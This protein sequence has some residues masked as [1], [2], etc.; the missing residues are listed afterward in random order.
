MMIMIGWTMATTTMTIGNGYATVNEDR[1]VNLNTGVQTLPLDFYRNVLPGSIMISSDCLNI[2][3]QNYKDAMQTLNDKTVTV[4]TTNGNV[5][6]G[7]V[8]SMSNN[9]ILTTSAQTIIIPM[10]NVDNIVYSGSSLPKLMLTVNSQCTGQN[11]LNIL[12]IT[13]GLSWSAEYSAI[14]EDNQ[15]KLNGIAHIT[16]TA[17]DYDDV[18]IT[19]VAGNINRVLPTNYYRG[20]PKMM[21]AETAMANGSYQQ[22]EQSQAYEYHTYHVPTPVNLKYGETTLTSIVNINVPAEKKYT[23]TISQW[24]NSRE[25]DPVDIGI[26]F[27]NTKENNGAVLPSGTVKVYTDNGFNGYMLAGE[28]T[29]DNTPLGENVTINTGKAFD[30]LASVK[31]TNHKEYSSRVEEDSYEVT[32]TN[33]KNESVTVEVISEMPRWRNWDITQSSISYVKES[34][35]KVKWHVEVPKNSETTFTYSVKKWW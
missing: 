17:G 3:S 34:A 12:Y 24:I 25:N 4:T 27:A 1:T 31:N 26:E 16:N 10:D 8:I 14:F 33:R 19:L 6:T 21:Y 18:D 30:I 5:Y 29:I 23:Y 7:K 2:I 15:L 22:I 11:T 32:L 9:I 20:Y 13:E 28:D 35:T